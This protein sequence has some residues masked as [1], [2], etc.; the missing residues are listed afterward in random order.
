MKHSPVPMPTVILSRSEEETEQAGVALA[1]R[2][3]AGA[4]VLLFGELGAGKTAFVRGLAAGIGVDPLE[5]SSPTFTL[6]Q[7]Y[8]GRLPLFH[9]D[10]YRL[11]AH[12]TE[13]LGLDELG[14]SGGVVAVEW[15]EKLARPVGGAIEVRI[16]DLGDDQREIVIGETKAPAHSDR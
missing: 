12:E 14:T 3:S 1:A 2:L 7:E 13:D 6:V 8:H 9:V 11:A 5:V 16:T 15:A 10:L 4:W